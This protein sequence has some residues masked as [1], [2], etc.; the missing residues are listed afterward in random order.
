MR[1]PNSHKN[2]PNNM[3]KDEY[4]CGCTACVFNDWNR[5]VVVLTKLSSLAATRNVITLI[6]QR[7]VSHTE[8]R[9]SGIFNRLVSRWR[10]C[11]I[12]RCK[13]DAASNWRPFCCGVVIRKIIAGKETYNKLVKIPRLCLSLC[14]WGLVCVL[15][16]FFRVTSLA[17]G[18]LC[19]KPL[20][21][22]AV[23]GVLGC[24]SPS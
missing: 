13:E 6:L 19:N 15:P 21:S 8:R 22:D 7:N 9:Y 3:N 2:I 23:L 24:A 16:L 20:P 17:L 11:V 1:Y 5:N 12:S 4:V 14:I 10:R 18:S